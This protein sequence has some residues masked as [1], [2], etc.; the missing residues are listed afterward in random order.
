MIGAL[1]TALKRTTTRN[2]PWCE[3]YCGTNDGDKAPLD[4]SFFL[5]V[6][7]ARRASVMSS[8][9]S[10]SPHD[11]GRVR[12]GEGGLPGESANCAMHTTV[13]SRRDCW[14][15][16]DLIID[17]PTKLLCTDLLLQIDRW[18]CTPHYCHRYTLI[19]CC[20]S[21]RGMWYEFHPINT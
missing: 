10:N 9:A 2:D 7:R 11:G 17:L 8:V 1:P 19:W 15:L 4:G 16:P 13:G 20:C 18:R 3:Y 5:Y 14:R 6:S 21:N 12:P